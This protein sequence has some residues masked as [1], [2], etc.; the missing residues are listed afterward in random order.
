MTESVLSIEV[1]VLCTVLCSSQSV[2]LEYQ[3]CILTVCLFRI[4]IS[5]V[6]LVNSV[7]VLSNISRVFALCIYVFFLSKEM[8]ICTHD[9]TY[10]V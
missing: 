7:F 5:V 1:A 9:A 2:R 3:S 8:Q 4:I 10:L 6:Y